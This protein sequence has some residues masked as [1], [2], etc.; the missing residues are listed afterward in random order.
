MEKTTLL[1]K[2]T[3]L[4]VFHKEKQKKININN[5]FPCQPFSLE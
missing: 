1:R 2:I 3:I 5:N 4:K